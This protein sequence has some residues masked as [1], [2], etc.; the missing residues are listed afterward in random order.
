MQTQVTG[1]NN[2]RDT[3]GF[4]VDGTGTNRGFV[5]WN[6]AFTSYTDPRTPKVRGSVNQLLGINDAGIAVGF[7]VDAGGNAH[8]V[9][10][11]QATGHFTTIKNAAIGPNSFATGINDSGAVVGYTMS[12]TDTYG[13]LLLPGGHV[14]TFN[15]PG[16][17][18]TLALGLNAHDEIVGSY[19]DGS[20][21]THGFTLTDPTGPVSH[22]T[23]ID[24][25]NASN[26]PGAGTVVNGLNNAGDLVGFYT[27]A[28]DNVNGL[29]A[30][31]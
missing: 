30:L 2:K 20:G 7:Y 23:Q 29:L 13:W 5:E 21:D 25:P 8:P 31:P 22:W 9:K 26:V 24:D 12:S 4:W 14:T 15:F 27:D 11:N 28:A 16:N 19:T 6:G 17:L 18:P 10:L 1:L 3:V